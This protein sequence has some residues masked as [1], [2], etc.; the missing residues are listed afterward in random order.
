MGQKELRLGVLQTLVAC[1][2]I[3]KTKKGH[4][5][6]KHHSLV[7]ALIATSLAAAPLTLASAAP[8]KAVHKAVTHKALKPYSTFLV[9]HQGATTRHLPVHSIGF[10]TPVNSLVGLLTQ[11]STIYPRLS[12]RSL[13]MEFVGATIV[14]H[15]TASASGAP[16][17][18]EA[19]VT[20]TWHLLS[21]HVIAL[22]QPLPQP[23][24]PPAPRPPLNDDKKHHGHHRPLPVHRHHPPVTPSGPTGVTGVTGMTGATGPTGDSGSGTPPV[25]P[26]GE[27]GASGASGASGDGGGNLRVLPPGSGIAWGP[28][29]PTGVTDAPVGDSGASGVTGPTGPTDYNPFQFETP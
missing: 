11:V 17:A 19:R 23:T 28:T 27:S 20:K 6:R 8:H 15:L 2:T 16:I 3:R 29:G 7:A 26:T 12:V 18:L 1:G 5:V 9:A 4:N 24:P 22:N 25:G 14:V 10:A 21:V 13:T